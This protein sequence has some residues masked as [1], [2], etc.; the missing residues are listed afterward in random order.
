MLL[1]IYNYIYTR[2]CNELMSCVLRII[3]LHLCYLFI[4]GK[5]DFRPS[6]PVVALLFKFL[7]PGK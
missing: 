3:C 4:S 1:N 2:S 6:D 7:S 5:I